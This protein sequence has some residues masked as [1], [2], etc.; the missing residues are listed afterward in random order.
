MKHPKLCWMPWLHTA[1]N[2][3]GDV[4]LC[5]IAK[6]DSGLNLNSKS[7][8][9]IWN[10][11]YYKQARLDMLEGKQISAC[12]TC[13]KEEDLGIQS[14]RQICNRIYEERLKKEGIEQITMLTDSTGHL[15]I[16]PP[17]I[18][19][20]LG[21]T[22]NLEC[23]MCGPGESSKWVRRSKFLANNLETKIKFVWDYKSKVDATQFDWYK[24]DKFW[25]DLEKIAPGLKHITFGGGEPL[26]VKEHKNIIKYL[27]DTGVSSNMSLHYHTNG[28]IYDQEVVDLWKQFK[29]V[30]V[31]LSIDGYGKVNELIRYP[32][33][34]SQVEENLR[35]Y[36]NCP[37]NVIL[38]INTTVQLLNV[39]YLDE[40]AQW[41]LNQNFKK[42]GKKTEGGIFFAS[43]LHY[44][45]YLSVQALPIEAKQEAAKKLQ[46][47]I[48][49]HSTNIGIMRLKSVIDFM[50]SSNNNSFDQTV[51]FLDKNYK[52]NSNHVSLDLLDK[53]LVK[54]KANE[55]C[56]KN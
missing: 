16:T 11:D 18:D 33:V 10:S 37:D 4:K 53:Y 23:A 54:A 6:N 30:K 36:D 22:C 45:D 42:I 29:E 3:N 44:P 27:V 2:P 31:M 51:D 50:M 49:K 41:L 13:W 17:T 19:M 24:T 47:C 32:S 34:W 12:E 40:F 15:S 46:T 52:F 28:T 14:H 20:R 48:D 56:S 35:K 55:I 38:S 26:Y 9:E 25:Q 1:T 7:I 43:L 5:C 21:N 8:E 39:F